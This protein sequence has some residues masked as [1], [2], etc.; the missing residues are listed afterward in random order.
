MSLQVPL[1]ELLEGLAPPPPDCAVGGIQCRSG[2]VRPGDLFAACRGTRRHGLEGLPEALR[3]GAAAVIYEPCPD[4]AEPQAEIPCVAVP[5]LSRVLS[6]IASRFYRDPSAR[7]PV[8]GI[9]GTDGKT[10]TSHLIAQILRGLKQDCGVI[11]TLGAGQI[12]ALHATGHTTPDAVRLQ[13]E[14]FEMV[15]RGDAVAV[16]EVSSHALEQHRCD[17]VHFET[18]VFTTLGRDHLDYHKTPQR[19]AAA[20]RRL[21]TELAPHRSVINVDDPFGRELAGQMDRQAQVHTCALEAPARSTARVTEMSAQGLAFEWAADGE[22]H[23]V[24]VPGLYGRFNVM[25]LLLSATAVHARGTPMDE[26]AAAMA[27]LSPVP[28]RLECVAHAPGPVFVDY[29]HTAD[30]LEAALAALHDHFGQAIHCVFGCGGERDRGK[31]PHMGEVA[32]RLAARVTLTDDNPRGESPRRIVEDILAGVPDAGRIEVEH[33]RA[34]AIRQAIRDAASGGVVLIAGKGHESEQVTAS[35]A[36]PFSD[37][38]AVRMA[39][40]AEA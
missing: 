39:L 8:I 12:D 33:D 27:G 15:Q 11:G 6:R 26:V 13:A 24:R 4:Q 23:A 14:L 7:L 35:G 29:A 40:E 34:R 19:Y 1:E 10:S 22:L 2:A 30:A 38:A 17:A 32:Q 5:E 20:K 37:H 31:R 21:F 16:L 9:T 28:G 25:N 36:R 3:R 18:A